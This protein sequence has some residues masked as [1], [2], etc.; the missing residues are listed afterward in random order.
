VPQRPK[1]VYAGSGNGKFHAIEMAWPLVCRRL[2]GCPNI[3]SSQLFEELCMQFPGRFN[4]WQ[5]KTLTKRVKVWRQDARARGLVI[6]HIK[7]RNLSHKPRG[8]R[9]DPFQAHWA[10][11]LQC[12]E[13]QPDQTALELLL[14]F[15]ARYP[16]RY[17]LRQLCTMQRRVKAWRREA[18]QRL[19]CEMKELTQNCTA[20]A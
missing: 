11:M 17:S 1:L 6:D 12:L 4:P 16:E 7:W 9:P 15:Q 18:V 14:E 13:A 2:E 3:N 8:I 19:I 10:E 5:L 20:T